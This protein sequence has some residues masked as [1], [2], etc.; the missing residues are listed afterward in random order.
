M[1]WIAP[2]EVDEIF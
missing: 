2:K 1:Q